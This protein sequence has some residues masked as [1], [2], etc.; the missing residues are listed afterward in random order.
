MTLFI[1]ITIQTCPQ[2]YTS[3]NY[4]PP[5]TELRILISQVRLFPETTYTCRIMCVCV[6]GGRGK[7]IV[8]YKSRQ[9]I[10]LFDT[11]IIKTDLSIGAHYLMSS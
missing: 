11:E 6:G 7:R 1:Y 5:P 9:K 3:Q 2:K 4:D 10:E 8:S